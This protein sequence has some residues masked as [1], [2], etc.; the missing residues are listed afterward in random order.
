M[1]TSIDF[2]KY[3]FLHRL[4]V[5]YRR[6][7]DR[8]ASGPFAG[9]S[10]PLLCVGPRTGGALRNPRRYRAVRVEGMT[11]VREL[12]KTYGAD[13]FQA[14]LHLNRI[15]LA[16]VRDGGTLIVVPDGPA[17]MAELSPFP[18]CLG[19]DDG[20]RRACCS[21]RGA[22]QAFAAYEAGTLVRW[23]AT[24]TGRRETPTPAGL[25]ATNW[26]SK[27]RRSSDNA[28]WLLPWYFNF[29]NAV[30]RVVP[31]VR[32]ARLSGQPRV[33]PAARRTTRSGST[34]GR[35]RGCST[36][37]GAKRRGL[38]HAGARVRRLRFR[39]ARPMDAAGRRSRATTITLDEL[40][41]AL[42][43]HQGDTGDGAAWQRVETAVSVASGRFRAL[44][45]TC[46]ACPWTGHWQLRT[47]G[48]LAEHDSRARGSSAR[49]TPTGNADSSAKN[50]GE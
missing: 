21:C 30:G 49:C 28:E 37:R 33:R 20:C 16:H 22:I 39:Q 19:Q 10:A 43:P 2:H 35:S 4:S 25:F 45:R 5:K 11:T 38:R 40:G 1:A 34:T 32:A 27:L 48:S 13:G 31:S 46:A 47:D 8:A 42:E 15:D 7:L 18:S 24:S 41:R 50:S 6:R 29:I 9:P 44:A 26:R 17:S 23:G 3:R 36:R 14:I 12:Q